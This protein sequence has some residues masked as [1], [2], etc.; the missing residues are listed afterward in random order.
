MIAQHVVVVG[1]V[2]TNAYSHSLLPHGE[3]NRASHLLLGVK[4]GD[5]FFNQADAK[6]FIV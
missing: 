5:L 3:V 6:H 4:F 2:G 1:Q